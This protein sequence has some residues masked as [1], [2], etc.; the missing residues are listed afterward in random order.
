MTE[1]LATLLLWR[2][3]FSD[4]N[5]AIR[6]LRKSSPTS[7]LGATSSQTSIHNNS[8]S[9]QISVLGPNSSRTSVLGPASS[10]TSDGDFGIYRPPTTLPVLVSQ[11]IPN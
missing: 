5:C 9:S 8:A 6:K 2:N 11:W 4:L 3:S 7:I 10:Q 1:V